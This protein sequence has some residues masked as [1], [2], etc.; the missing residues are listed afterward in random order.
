MKAHRVLIT[1]LISLVLLLGA[2]AVLT[3][4]QETESQESKAPE[5]PADSLGTRFTYQGQLEL[6]DEP[7]DDTCDMQFGLYE[8]LTPAS[9]VGI[10]LT[11]SVL[12]T[13]GLFA[14]LLDFGNAFRGARCWLEVA[15][16]CG[17]GHYT[18]LGR[19]ELTAAPY[20]LYAASAG[21]LHSYPLSTTAPISGQ[22]LEWDGATW[23]PAADD[24][25]T[26]YPGNQLDLSGTTFHV[27]EG[28]GSDLNADLLDNQH[29]YFYRN[30][31]SI[32]AGTLDPSYYSAHADLT[33]ENRLGDNAG[34][35]AQNN[36]VLQPTLNA[37]QVD[38]Y[39]AADL[40]AAA[41]EAEI[42]GQIDSAVVTEMDSF[43]VSVPADG[44]LT[45]IIMASVWLDCDATSSS[46]RLCW[47][48]RIGICD[49]PSSSEF[50]GSSY[51]QSRLDFEDPDDV[52]NVNAEKWISIAR[53]VP[54]SAGPRGFYVNGASDASGMDF[55]INGYVTAIFTPG[56]L[57]VVSP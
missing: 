12:V 36:G 39:H 8:G 2:A 6:H 46:S 9:Q 57:T 49:T 29:G 45:V 21:A 44:T 26:Y 48:T 27:V 35:I 11:R 38:N 43:T 18:I 55:R 50:C 24:G 33:V 32:N 30:A 34:D 52:S 4:A 56:S 42:Y 16:D 5:A 13:D 3:H 17:E 31:D 28:V 53:T 25:T 7:V 15:V 14:V 20:A 47:G 54:V 37:D 10:T 19:Q 41:G 22:V 40:M 1:V 51:D 23:G